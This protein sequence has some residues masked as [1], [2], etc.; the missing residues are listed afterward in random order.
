MPSRTWEYKTPK[1]TKL[2]K[3]RNNNE[4]IIKFEVISAVRHQPK[5]NFDYLFTQLVVM[6]AVKMLVRAVIAAG[7]R[8]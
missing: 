8:N 2:V 4:K 7:E 5:H 3:L 1:C 6:V